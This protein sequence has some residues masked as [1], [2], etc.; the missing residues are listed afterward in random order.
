MFWA[1]P[2]EMMMDGGFPI[3]L[4]LFGLVAAFLVLRLIS[5]LGK[6]TGFEQPTTR[7]VQQPAPA[8]PNA[9]VIEAVAEVP[10]RSLPDPASPVGQTLIAMTRIDPHFQP[11]RFLDGAEAAFRIIVMA[12]ANG[13]RLRLRPLLSDATYAAFEGAISAREAAGHTQ[14][15]DIRSVENVTIDHAELAGTVATIAVRF[16]SDQVNLTHGPDGAV[17]TG[18]DAVTEIVD[19]WSFERDLAKSDPAWRLVAARSA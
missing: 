19:L 6:R 5:V 8:A 1:L 18:T 7:L 13:D 11:Q 15:T 17:L 2:L 3:D 16:V 14:T 9:P 10:R 4:V 12:Y